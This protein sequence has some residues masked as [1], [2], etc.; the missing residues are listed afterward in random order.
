MILQIPVRPE[1]MA[2]RLS[3]NLDGGNYRLSLRFN[4]RDVHWY[5]DIER[6]GEVLIGGLKLI[7]TTDLLQ[8]F[9]H[10]D[11]LPV[12]R[13]AVWDVEGKRQDPDQTLFGDRVLMLY[14][15]AA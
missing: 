9:R 15:E 3:V 11:G 13:L 5:L 10:I 14:E 6:Q 4:R 1:L 8:Q 12:G 7:H 2:H